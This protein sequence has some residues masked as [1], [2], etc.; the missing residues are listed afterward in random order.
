M[1][2]T[3]RTTSGVPSSTSPVRWGLVSASMTVPPMTRSRVRRAMARVDP[4]TTWSNVVS[5]VSREMISPVRAVSK[6]P[7]WSASTRSKTAVRTS[8]ITRSPIHPSR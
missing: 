2:H 5:E 8:A 1:S 6:N 3:G 4:T 7:T